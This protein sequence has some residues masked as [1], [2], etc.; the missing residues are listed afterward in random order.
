[1]NQESHVAFSPASVFTGQSPEEGEMYRQLNTDV[2]GDIPITQTHV[3]QSEHVPVV[4]NKTGVNTDRNE[5]IRLH[6][7]IL[8][9]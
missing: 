1:M 3:S 6:Q 8:V 7:L 5:M 4:C 9:Q 2:P